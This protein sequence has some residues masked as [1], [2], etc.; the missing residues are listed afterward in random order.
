MAT[1]RDV[2]AYILRERGSMSGM[3]LQKLLYYSQAWHLVWTEGSPLFPDRIEA[4]ANGPVVRSVYALHR[5]EMSVSEI[6]G[7][8][9]DALTDLEREHINIVLDFY[10]SRA[11]YELS[12]MTHR[13]QPWL[14]A[15]GDLEPGLPGQTE[16]PQ[17]SMYEYYDSLVGTSEG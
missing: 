17:Q 15:R 2:A 4:W 7:G 10:G 16:I 14:I 12:E 9:P 1:A 5:Q 13:E 3:K 6:A 8:N 11:A